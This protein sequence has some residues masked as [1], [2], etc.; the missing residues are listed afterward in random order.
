MAERVLLAAFFLSRQR[1]MGD[2]V[3]GLKGCLLSSTLA[4][5]DGVEQVLANRAGQ[6]SC[7]RH[8]LVLYESL[9]TLYT[10]G[11]VVTRRLGGYASATDPIDK[12]TACEGAP[13]RG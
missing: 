4:R 5:G 2:S 11:S 6:P 7:A 13:S 9:I 12:R 3:E 10:I 8:L 1:S